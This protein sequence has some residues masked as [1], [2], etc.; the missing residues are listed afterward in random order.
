MAH[1]VGIAKVCV[2]PIVTGQTTDCDIILSYND[3]F[4]DTIS[5]VE[6]FDRVDPLGH[7]TRVPAAGN[8]PITAVFGNTTC[9]IGAFAACT[10]GPDIGGGVGIVVFTS[11][12]Y[13]TQV[14]DS[15]PLNDRACSARP[16][17]Q[18]ISDEH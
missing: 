6:A 2:S 9:V 4:L 14:T 18:S 13:V 12:T 8:L 1:G 5:V 7:N 15:D 11:N 10:I 17:L 16:I 3:G